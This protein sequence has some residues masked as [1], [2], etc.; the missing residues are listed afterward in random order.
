MAFLNKPFEIKKIAFPKLLLDTFLF[1]LIW[2]R[3]ST[4]RTI[5]PATNCGKKETKKAK[6]NMFFSGFKLPR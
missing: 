4:A 1:C 5:G 3:K 6:F 2:G